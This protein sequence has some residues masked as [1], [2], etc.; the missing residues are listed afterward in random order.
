M[1]IAVFMDAM[2]KLIVNS[3]STMAMLQKIVSYGWEYICF[4]ERDLFYRDG[5]VFADG[6]TV[7]NLTNIA[8]KPVGW[9]EIKKCG[10]CD[11]T[12]FDI[13]LVRKD[14]PFFATYLYATQLLD[15]VTRSGVIV[16]NNPQALRDANEKLYTLWFDGCFPKTLVSCNMQILRQFWERE[17]HI[18]LKPLHGAGGKGIFIV[19]K[20]GS[21][22]GVILETLTQEGSI[23]VNVSKIISP[24]LGSTSFEEKDCS[25]ILKQVTLNVLLFNSLKSNFEI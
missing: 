13:I 3:D 14:P 4:T 24:T 2:E 25:P 23:S 9:N 21:N 7:V 20:T 10:T 1:R 8:L 12:E 19:D 16:S 18:V 5:R 22:L 15:L 11:L 17:Q 6:F